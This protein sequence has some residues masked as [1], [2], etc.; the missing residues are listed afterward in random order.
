MKQINNRA[1]VMYFMCMEKEKYKRRK[2]KRTSAQSCFAKGG[3][4]VQRRKKKRECC[5]LWF[6]SKLFGFDLFFLHNG[7]SVAL[8]HMVCYLKREKMTRR[9]PGFTSPTQLMWLR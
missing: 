7:T 6:L 5:F 8:M 9:I 3:Q 4:F 1:F 2:K